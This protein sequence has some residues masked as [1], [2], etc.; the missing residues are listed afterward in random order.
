MSNVIAIGPLGLQNG[1]SKS[2][3]EIVDGIDVKYVLNT[4]PYPN[5]VWLSAIVYVVELLFVA[6]SIKVK[7]VY[8]TPSR[9]FS[10]SIRDIILL[11]LLRPS[12]CISHLHG[13]EYNDWYNSLPAS[14]RRVYNVTVLQ[15]IT[16]WV[17]LE[18]SMVSICVSESSKIHVIPNF[19]DECLGIQQT[20][21]EGI[22]YFSH[23]SEAKGF[24]DF[25]YIIKELRRSKVENAVYIAG[26]LEKSMKPFLNELL[27]LRNVFY[28]GYVIDENKKELFS[29][30]RYHLFP[31]RYTTEASPISLIETMSAGIIPLVYDHNCL[32]EV[33]HCP[34]FVSSELSEIIVKLTSFEKN[35]SLRKALALKVREYCHGKY[36]KEHS[37]TAL[38]ELVNSSD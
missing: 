38:R 13:M 24:K 19:F 10:G 22:L 26:G 4:R 3:E 15:K 8:F 31:S 27:G 6:V 30:I 20:S 7:T 11:S 12:K 37:I 5:S 18:N 1:Q 25:C 14:V 16:D 28:L 29:E 23:L 17:V 9:T 34:E 21:G 32:A 36:G 35:P 2:F 33:V